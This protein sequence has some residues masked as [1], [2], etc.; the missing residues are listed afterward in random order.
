[1]WDVLHPVD[2][3]SSVLDATPAPEPYRPPADRI[4]AGDPVQR[5]WNLHSSDDGHFHS[6][7]WECQPGKWRVVFTET[8][9]CHL[10][11]GVIVVTSQD[12][13]TRRFVAGE[14]FVSPSGFEG[15]WE[16]VELAR[17]RYA[18]YE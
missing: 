1:M 11:E 13:A 10:L 6:G 17:K 12:G 9:F 7:V 3:D 5:V 15:T 16:V 2:F 4:L 14:A 8:E 18:I